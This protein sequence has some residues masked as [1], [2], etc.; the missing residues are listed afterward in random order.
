MLRLPQ[1]R[2]SS[3]GDPDPIPIF[4]ELLSIFCDKH[5]VPRQETTENGRVQDSCL[6]RV[7][8]VKPQPKQLLAMVPIPGSI[9]SY[10]GDVRKLGLEF[11]R[12]VCIS[13]VAP[14]QITV[15]HRRCKMLASNCHEGLGGV[16]EKLADEETEDLDGIV[17]L[18]R[19]TSVRGNFSVRL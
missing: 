13:V 14:M 18:L 12:A 10:Q 3:D 15:R 8:V 6:S 7:C 19:R 11:A 9:L 2:G 16:E 5:Q 1:S 17:A 4:W